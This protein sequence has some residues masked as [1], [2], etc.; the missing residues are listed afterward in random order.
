MLNEL[1]EKL[2]LDKNYKKQ[3]DALDK[4]MMGNLPEI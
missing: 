2:K 1:D 4:E 3:I